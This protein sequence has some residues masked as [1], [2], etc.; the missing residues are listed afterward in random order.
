[1]FLKEESNL[2]RCILRNLYEASMNEADKYI[3]GKGA[4]LIT[5]EQAQ[6]FFNS[7]SNKYGDH[8]QIIIRGAGNEAK[9]QGN[10]WEDFTDMFPQ[11]KD[12][13][14]NGKSYRLNSSSKNTENPIKE[15]KTFSVDSSWGPLENL[16]LKRSNGTSF[17]VVQ[18][19][20][21]NAPTVP[22][23]EEKIGLPVRDSSFVYGFFDIDLSKEV[24][25]EQLKECKKLSDEDFT[26][27]VDNFNGYKELRLV[28]T[29][30]MI[31]RI[32]SEAEKLVPGHLVNIL[33]APER[34]RQ[35]SFD[36][37]EEKHGNKPGLWEEICP[38]AF[39][40]DQEKYYDVIVGGVDPQTA[41]ECLSAYFDFGGFNGPYEGDP[42]NA[43]EAIEWGASLERDTLGFLYEEIEKMCTPEEHEAIANVLRQG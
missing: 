36:K 40:N 34:F 31:Q 5:P 3:P 39:D 38:E 23:A 27:Y 21:S 6:E 18:V 33:N 25:E 22:Q 32:K 24:S 12:A 4:V 42:N 37:H 8:S 7:I 19:N 30:S 43:E 15:G 11:F 28:P 14:F 10:Y 35:D 2:S 17:E 9:Y 13:K 29:D 1:M 41:L 26:V 20:R 16:T